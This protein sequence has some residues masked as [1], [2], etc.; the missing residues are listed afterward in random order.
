MMVLSVLFLLHDDATVPDRRVL[1]HAWLWQQQGW[2]VQAI[3][4]DHVATNG[5]NDVSSAV[6]SEAG[7]AFESIRLPPTPRAH[8][9]AYAK[10]LSGD[11]VPIIP[12]SP[13]PWRVKLGDWCF[14]LHQKYYPH[15]KRSLRGRL[16]KLLQVARTSTLAVWDPLPFDAPLLAAASNKLFHAVV[17]NDLTT[18]TAGA[19]LAAKA[20]VPLVYDAHE[21]YCEQVNFNAG[22]KSALYAAE[23]AAIGKADLVITVSDPIADFLQIRYDLKQRPLVIRNVPIPMSAVTSRQETYLRRH[24]DAQPDDTIF[25]FHGGFASGRNLETII[26]GFAAAKL[27]N[28]HLLFMG[29]GK[30]ETLRHAIEQYPGL[31]CKLIPPVQPS[32]VTGVI[33]SADFVVLP[34]P[35]IDLNT[36]YCLP[37]KL[38]DAFAAGVPVLA[39]KALPAVHKLLAQYGNG[40]LADMSSIAAVAAGFNGAASQKEELKAQAKIAQ[41]TLTVETEMRVLRQALAATIWSQFTNY[42]LDAAALTSRAYSPTEIAQ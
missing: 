3:D 16:S 1:N 23:K 29:F 21:L 15:V 37:N 20:R 39:N 12:P 31:A 8:S 18:L 28:S 11:F 32:E 19:T 13:Q 34:Y 22:M 4:F 7:A 2:R 41:R 30:A 27:K 42:S 35:P 9:D 40:Y 5:G 25:V 17:A 14:R 24:A 38:F 26:H 33:A 6:R 36:T 10:V